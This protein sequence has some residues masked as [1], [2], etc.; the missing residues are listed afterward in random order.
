MEKVFKEGQQC[1]K[2]GRRAQRQEDQHAHRPLLAMLLM[3]EL[4][5]TVFRGVPLLS[6]SFIISSTSRHRPCPVMFLI[7]FMKSFRDCHR[8]ALVQSRRKTGHRI[9]K[10]IKLPKLQRFKRGAIENSPSCTAVHSVAS[11]CKK[12]ISTRFGRCVS[13]NTSNP[14]YDD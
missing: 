9:A 1:R 3:H 8:A 13:H 10:S 5:T 14:K 4:N 6:S 12:T 11:C 7:L 2:K